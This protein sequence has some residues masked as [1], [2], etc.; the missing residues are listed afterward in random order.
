MKKYYLKATFKTKF[1]MSRSY[2]FEERTNESKQHRQSEG[3]DLNSLK[4]G[5]ET[6][7]SKN[8]IQLIMM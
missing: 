6:S 5:G 3:V 8:I 7:I 1:I 2:N 4:V